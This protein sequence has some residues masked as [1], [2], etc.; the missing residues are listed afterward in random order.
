MMK[1]IIPHVLIVLAFVLLT[2][3]ITD[4]INSTMALVNNDITKV[5]V[6]ISCIV[7]I[8]CGI[9]YISDQRR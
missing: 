6:V 3:F 5:L 8:V 9:F 4:L 2:I 1:K 7:M